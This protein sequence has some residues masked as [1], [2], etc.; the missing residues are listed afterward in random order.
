MSPVTDNLTMYTITIGTTLISGIL[1]YLYTSRTKTKVTNPKP[2]RK[3]VKKKPF[4]MPK[5]AIKKGY[6]L[7]PPDMNTESIKLLHERK[8]PAIWDNVLFFPGTC[9]TK[10]DSPI[11]QLKHYFHKARTSIYICMYLCSN[12]S[13]T[14]CIREKFDEGLVVEIISEYDTWTAH[15]SKG[16]IQLAR[17]GKAIS[18]N[19]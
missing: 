14:D 3:V 13:L 16:I 15:N 9:P 18:L 11:K 7:E 10:P 12:Y 19:L 6:T 1:Y 4:V 8:P 5:W 17:H 2:R